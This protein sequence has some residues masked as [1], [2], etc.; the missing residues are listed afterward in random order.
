MLPVPPVDIKIINDPQAAIE[1]QRITSLETQNNKLEDRATKHSYYIFLSEL[2]V[3]L[4]EYFL[5]YIAA[6]NLVIVYAF[7]VSLYL[8][9]F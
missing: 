1:G 9:L 5:F 2:L 4:K 7:M 6:S 8:L 3:H